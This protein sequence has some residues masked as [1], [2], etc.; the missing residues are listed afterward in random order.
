MRTR[1]TI[2]LDCKSLLANIVSNIIYRMDYSMKDD[3]SRVRIIAS[4]NKEN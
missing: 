2:P 4:Y 1:P 3:A